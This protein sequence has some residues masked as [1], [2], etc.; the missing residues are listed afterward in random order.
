MLKTHTLQPST[1]ALIGAAAILVIVLG[2]AA[3]LMTAPTIPS[4][5]SPAENP[6]SNSVALAP[7]S[8]NPAAAHSV[9][10]SE[11]T[12]RNRLD[13]AYE[14]HQ[15]ALVQKLLP[16]LNGRYERRCCGFPY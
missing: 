13:E 14:R 6:A 7:V 2:V 4:L 1:I 5:L 11:Q 8:A 16:I 15:T 12:L 9:Y 10:V 3:H